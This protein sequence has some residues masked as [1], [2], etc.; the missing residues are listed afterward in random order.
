LIDIYGHCIIPKNTYLFRG[1][2]D[3]DTDDCKFFATKLWVAGAFND[4]IQVWKMKIDIQ[5]LFLVECLDDR[6]R[7]ISSL[8]QL[9]NTF[10]P[11]DNNSDSNDLDI[12]NREI[13]RRNRLVGKL[14]EKYKTPGWLTSLENKVEIKVCLFEKDANAKQFQL[15]DTVKRK[16]KS[17]IKDSLDRITIFPSNIFM[18]RHITNSTNTSQI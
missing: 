16:N 18:I 5:I 6:S 12:K 17:C 10:F 7:S 11:V 15:V 1:H 9:F 3:T 14:F 4:T 13:N 2:K 8:P